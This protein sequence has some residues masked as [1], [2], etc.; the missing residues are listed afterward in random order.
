MEET[1]CFY[2]PHEEHEHPS[3]RDIVDSPT[4]TS[5]NQQRTAKWKEK[6]KRD[7]EEEEIS[8]NPIPQL[9]H[10]IL[11]FKYTKPRHSTIIFLATTAF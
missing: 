3:L 9:G 7:E 1:L 5:S 6:G 8:E 11:I 2:E 4:T 10:N